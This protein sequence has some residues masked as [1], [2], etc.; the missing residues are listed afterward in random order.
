LDVIEFYDQPLS[1]PK[2]SP[3]LEIVAVIEIIGHPA[4]SSG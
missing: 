3:G 4:P 2:I 1:V